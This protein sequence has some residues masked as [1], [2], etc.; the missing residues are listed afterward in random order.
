[1]ASFLRSL[2]N[3]DAGNT[4]RKVIGDVAQNVYGAQLV[5]RAVRGSHLC[6]RSSFPA[7][8]KSS[9]LRFSLSDCKNGRGERFRTS[10][11]LVP[12]S[13]HSNLNA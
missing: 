1:M 13:K 11:P 3:D 4:R 12:N 2:L 9:D 8:L 10:D 5:G 7:E 6:R